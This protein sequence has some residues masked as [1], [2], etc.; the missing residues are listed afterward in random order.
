MNKKSH[1]KTHKKVKKGGEQYASVLQG[2]N[3]YGVTIDGQTPSEIAQFGLLP[4]NDWAAGLGQNPGVTTQM[5]ADAAFPGQAG[6]KRKNKGGYNSNLGFKTYPTYCDGKDNWSQCGLSKNFGCNAGGKKSKN[7]KDK[8]KRN[9]KSGGQYASVL[10]G[11][12]QYGVT[13]DGQTPS[14]IAQ[15]G[16]LPNNDWVAGLGQNPGVT[17]QMVADAAFPDQAG[18]RKKKGGYNTL[19]FKTYPTYCDGKDNWSQCGLSKNFG[20]NTG[21]KKS[22]KSKRH[23]RNKL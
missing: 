5:S 4:G 3:R 6:G 9:K 10:K 17:T 13:I 19:G 7:M 16:L 18:G 21:G 2:S 15:F 23:R 11:N 22:K 1:K 20:C 12:Q 14:E 8:K